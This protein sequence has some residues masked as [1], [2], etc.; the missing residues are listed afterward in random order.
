[1]YQLEERY[2]TAYHSRRTARVQWIV[3]HYT[4]TAAGAKANARTFERKL[5]KPRS[6]H[7]LVEGAVVLATVREN[8]AAWHIG[9]PDESKKLPVYNGNAIGVDLC[10]QKLV[11]PK[12]RLH[13][14]DQD[15]YF[16][17]ETEATAAELIAEIMRRHSIPLDHVVRHYDVTG[18]LCPRPFVGADINKVYKESGNRRWEGFKALIAEHLRGAIR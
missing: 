6:T 15:W 18:K 3:V 9:A 5:E 8:R 13:A 4:G 12:G 2:K 10:E 1:M 16:T 17:D 14:E 11:M 7:Y